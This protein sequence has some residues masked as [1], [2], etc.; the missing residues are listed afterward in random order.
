METIKSILMPQTTK[1]KINVLQN[2]DP[3]KQNSL[4]QKYHG[5]SKGHTGP[6]IPFPEDV[7]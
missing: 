6:T 5:K 1:T 4:T 3:L 7:T 2:I